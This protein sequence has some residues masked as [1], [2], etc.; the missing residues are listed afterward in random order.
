MS[1]F[2]YTDED[3][4]FYIK[5]LKQACDKHKCDIHAYVLITNHVHLLIMP[6]KKESISKVIQ[7]IG[8]Y[9]VQYFNYNYNRTG[10]FWEGRYKA[11]LLE[12]KVGIEDMKCIRQLSIESDRIDLYQSSPTPLIYS[13]PA[14]NNA[15]RYFSAFSSKFNLNTN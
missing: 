4:Q 11:T 13:Q 14:S 1:P 3:Y 2:F 9:Y 12:Q 5:K 8:R 15:S 7:M 6:N 10:T